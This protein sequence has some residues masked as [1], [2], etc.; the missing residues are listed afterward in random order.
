MEA[1]A[2][3]LWNDPEFQPMR[4]S[5]MD[6]FACT[7][8][9][10]IVK[11]QAMWNHIDFPRPPT[12]PAPPAPLRSPSPSPQPPI[13]PDEGP[14][15]LAKKKLTFPDFDENASVPNKLPF[16]PAQFALDKVKAME[17]VELWYFTSEGI[18]DASKVTPMADN[19]SFG[20]LNTSSGFTFQHIRASKAS[21]NVI[22]DEALT[23]DQISTARH[24]IV[25]AAAGWP[26][27]HRRA[28][29]EYFI[30][31]EVLKAA[32]SNLRALIL[33]QATVR[34]LWHSSLKGEGQCFNLAHIHDGLLMKLEN[35]IRDQDTE[36]N[37]KEILVS[38]VCLT[39]LKICL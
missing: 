4:Q 31:L 6:R 16:F 30:E 32:S 19:D 34:R 21:R 1:I 3:P 37:T 12:P 25:N 33:Y 27:K 15:P 5:I 20:L 35:R 23:W 8:D 18:L 39:P 9:E 36:K 28:L 14:L 24:N 26:E 10:A 2:P 29:A 38:N 22:C 7:E 13:L 17:Y 11:L